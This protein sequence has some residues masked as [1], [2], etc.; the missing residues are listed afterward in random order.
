MQ[1]VDKHG[2]HVTLGCEF[3]EGQCDHSILFYLPSLVNIIIIFPPKEMK[4]L[5]IRLDSNKDHVKSTSQVMYDVINHL[6]SVYGA[7]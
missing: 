6:D 7:L 3:A 4:E 2:S 1:M 5:H